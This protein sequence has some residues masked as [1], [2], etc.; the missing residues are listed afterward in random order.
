MGKYEEDYRY[1]LSRASSLLC[2]A[3]LAAN[4]A[5]SSAFSVVETPAPRSME[6]LVLGTVALPNVRGGASKLLD[7]AVER[8]FCRFDLARTYGMGQSER[9]FGKWLEGSGVD[10]STLKLVTKGGMGDDKYGNPDR[11][12]CTRESLRSE[13]T[14]SLEALKTD[15][16]DL[17]ML[18]RDDPRIPA[19]EFVDW[20]N[21]LKRD[22]L[23]RRWGVSNW[24]LRRIHHACAY[25]DKTGQEPLT[26]TSPQLSLA[27]PSNEI[28]PSTHSVSC[29]SKL[30]EINWYRDHNVEVMGWE[31]LAKGFMAVPT[32]WRQHEIHYSTF[33]GPDADAGTDTWRLQRIQRAYCTPANYRRRD[34][35]ARLA[36]DS[37]LSLAQVS[38]LYCL[39]KG[40]HVSVLVGADQ[41]S[42]LDEMAAIRNFALDEEATD[43]LT[44][45][46]MDPTFVSRVATE[47]RGWTMDKDDIEFVQM[48]REEEDLFS[49]ESDPTVLV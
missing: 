15:Y 49:P 41:T 21:E 38:L 42:H 32:L 1:G 19:E 31:A 40:E 25:A 28:W 8:G 13:L 27:V 4:T 23:I 11:P 3:V 22:G 24:S 39:S 43:C 2:I 35:A 12:M 17:Y 9:L 47:L 34:I 44:A 45:A 16:V 29:P 10:R 5:T 18:H 20:M 33:H 36:K 7:A 30:G 46:S 37:G 14:T 26:A 48:S 6:Q